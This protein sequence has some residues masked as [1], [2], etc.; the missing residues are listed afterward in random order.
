MYEIVAAAG[1]AWWPL[2]NLKTA[3]APGEAGA[4]SLTCSFE[5]PS[6]RDM[7]FKQ[8]QVSS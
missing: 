4:S 1:C 5:A 6:L 3:Q 7:S 2:T 8:L